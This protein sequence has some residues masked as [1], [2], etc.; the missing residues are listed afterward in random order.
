MRY[1]TL[2]HRLM[3]NT[4]MK[5]VRLFGLFKVCNWCKHNIWL[6]RL[7]SLYTRMAF[8]YDFTV[9]TVDTHVWRSHMTLTSVQLIHTYDVHIWLYRL[10]SWYTR[11]TF[12]YD[13]N[14]YNWCIRHIWLFRLLNWLHAFPHKLHINGFSPVCTRIC[15]LSV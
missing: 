10:Y 1:Y 2:Y 4:Y 8:T 5:V 12:T 15:R 9:C 6:Y 3:L 13:F 11:M 7:Y 14:V